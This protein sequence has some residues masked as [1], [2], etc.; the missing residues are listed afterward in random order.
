MCGAR[1]PARIV[2]RGTTCSPPA[3]FPPLQFGRRSYRH[4]QA[5]S[6]INREKGGFSPDSTRPCFL[7]VAR[8]PTDPVFRDL[9]AAAQAHAGGNRFSRTPPKVAGRNA[10]DA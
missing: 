3:Y 4:L 10:V 8:D 1:A 5:T 2:S 7:R 6:V 9:R